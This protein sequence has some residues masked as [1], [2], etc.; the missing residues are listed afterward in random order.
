LRK[1][2]SIDAFVTRL[3]VNVHLYF[4][5]ISGEDEV[6]AGAAR[7]NEVYKAL[8]EVGETRRLPEVGDDKTLDEGEISIRECRKKERKIR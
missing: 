4:R 1:L 8:P 3:Y 6:H 7:V 5:D 2:T